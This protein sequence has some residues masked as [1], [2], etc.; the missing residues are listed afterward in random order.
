MGPL[1]IYIYRYIYIYVCVYIYTRNIARASRALCFAQVRSD[2][3]LADWNSDL[4]VRIRTPRGWNQ[5]P[6]KLVLSQICYRGLRFCMVCVC[7]YG[8][9]HAL[10][11]C[12]P[13]F[14][15]LQVRMCACVC[16]WKC[17]P[18]PL[19]PSFR[20]WTVSCV[21]LFVTCSFSCDFG[22]AGCPSMR[23]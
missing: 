5:E 7:L 23:L 19:S 11:L 16:L 6:W 3:G 8:M 2:S 18:C 10:C 4:E 1:T 9:V 20:M 17:A 12:V 22:G 15:Y 21:C 13:G 14:T